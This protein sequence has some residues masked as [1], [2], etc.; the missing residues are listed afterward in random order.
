MKCSRGFQVIQM[1]KYQLFDTG[2]VLE[3]FITHFYMFFPQETK[4]WLL[5]FL[6][7]YMSFPEETE[8]TA[9][10]K[11]E[12]SKPVLKMASSCSLTHTMGNGRT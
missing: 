4:F 12:M 1:V 9:E 5:F 2:S 8:Q 6:F 10:D 11:V 7:K 3:I